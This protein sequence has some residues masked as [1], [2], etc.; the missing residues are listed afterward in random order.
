MEFEIIKLP[1]PSNFGTNVIS[2]KCKDNISCC[3]AKWLFGPQWRLL[4]VENMLYNSCIKSINASVCWLSFFCV[5]VLQGACFKQMGRHKQDVKAMLHLCVYYRFEKC[6]TQ[7]FHRRAKDL[8]TGCS[9]GLVMMEETILK[10][11]K[12]RWPHTARLQRVQKNGKEK[13]CFNT[14]VNGREF[15]PRYVDECQCKKGPH[16]IL[17]WSIK[18]V[19][20][21]PRI[22]DQNGLKPGQTTRQNLSFHM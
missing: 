20:K 5:Y 18:S 17:A 21:R 16:W 3:C 22:V 10:I 9:L 4:S 2:S 7:Y 13:Q 8:W 19:F 11:L 1:T 15:P 12:R 14:A 6:W